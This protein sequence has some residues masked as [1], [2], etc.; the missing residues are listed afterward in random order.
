M[1]DEIE[2]AQR[3]VEENLQSLP[4]S[5]A[6]NPHGKLLNLITNFTARVK[7][8]TTGHESSRELFEGFYNQFERLENDILS[9]RLHFQIPP[10]PTQAQKQDSPLGID[11]TFTSAAHADY[12][13]PP[14]SE[15]L[16]RKEGPVE[17]EAKHEP[18]RP[19]QRL[20]LGNN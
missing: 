4:E 7:E 12:Y 14:E 11:Y 19:G 13:S 10:R 20:A 9:T 17:A 1:A 16:A 18:K 3:Q 5:F 6:E 8:Y 15:P 2:S